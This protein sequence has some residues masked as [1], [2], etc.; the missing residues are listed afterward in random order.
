MIPKVTLVRH[1][2]GYVL[3]LEFLDGTQGAIDL[4]GE[5][6]GPVFEPVRDV[7]VFRQV[8]IHPE[9]RTLVWP[10][11]ADLAPEF[12]YEQVRVVVS[13]ASRTPPEA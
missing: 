13:A 11:G 7:N 10:N 8:T 12:L 3:H 4:G 2:R 5:L 9:F 6:H 1:V